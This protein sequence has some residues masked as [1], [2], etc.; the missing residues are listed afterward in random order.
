MPRFLL[1]TDVLPTKKHTAG[2]VLDQF[3]NHL[4]LNYEL[5]TYNIQSTTLPTYGVSSRITGKMRWTTKPAE[6]WMAPMFAKNWLEKLSY[7]ESKLILN[8]I[9]R[10]ISQQR[11]DC[12]FVV[13]QGQTMFRIAIQLH[14]NGIEFSTFH[15]DPLSWWQIHNKAQS[16][17]LRL[18][19]DV[20]PALNSGGVHILPSE[21]FAEYLQLDS[22]NHVVINLAQES[23]EN[24]RIEQNNLFRICFSGQSYAKKEIG[25]FLESMEQIHW[26]IDDFEVELH[27]FGNAFLGNSKNIFH[28][29]WVDPSEL[30]KQLS[31]YDCAL[32]PYPSDK[33][34][35]EVAKY[36]FPSK[37]S[38]YMAANLPVMFI[39]SELNPFSK[40]QMEAIFPV[41]ELKIDM[42]I[43]AIKSL[44][45]SRS[46]FTNPIPEIFHSN[47]ST[48]AQKLVVEEFLRLQS[49]KLSLSQSTLEVWGNR[50]SRDGQY[51]KYPSASLL[52]A[53]Y[54]SKFHFILFRLPGHISSR[55]KTF[56]SRLSAKDGQ[57]FKYPSASL[58]LANSLSRF[59]D[60]FIRLPRHIMSR[61]KTIFLRLF[62]SKARALGGFIGL[63]YYGLLR[64]LHKLDFRE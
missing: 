6:S 55:A 2:L 53:K 21:N 15:W 36:S 1:I 49:S 12:I 47:F 33:E 56:F 18:L 23:M 46:R 20:V 64:L 48:E 26:Q 35:S 5:V 22:E 57:Y 34:F 27:I 4:P 51:F 38:T 28:H 8:D 44:K 25:F 58:L 14:Q 17:V 9:L 62:H 42:M 41:Y 7:L 52:L 10:E 50:Q 45:H 31:N 11:P 37:F 24:E 29:G 16:G 30:I 3:F 32:L 39:G 54:L 43:E 19:E 61:V 13:L 40:K 59:Q 63:L 60:L